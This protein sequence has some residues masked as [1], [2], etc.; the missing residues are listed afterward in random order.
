MKLQYK[1]GVFIH[2]LKNTFLNIFAHCMARSY[3]W[4]YRGLIWGHRSVMHRPT[5]YL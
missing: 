4:L 2:A 1:S 5:V 3:L